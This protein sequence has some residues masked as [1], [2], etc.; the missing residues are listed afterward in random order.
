MRKSKTKFL[1]SSLII[2]FLILCAAVAIIV[3]GKNM[4]DDYK[5]QID[6]MQYEMD[7][8]KQTVYVASDEIKAGMTLEEGVNIYKQQIYTGLE[9]ESYISEEDIG[10]VAI[11]D[12]PAGEPIM[13]STVTP[14]YISPDTREY[15]IA[16]AALM[17]DQTEYE[18][19]DVRIMF[20]TGEDY[21]VLSKK[22]VLN[23]KLESSVFYSYLNEDEIMRMASAVIDAY[24]V[25]GT[26]IYTTRYVE[27]NLQDEA[28][29]NYLVKAETIDLI[30]RDP[31]ITRIAEDTLNLQAR[32]DL[33]NRLK[34]LTEDQLK[35]VASGH[36][37]E[38]TAKNAVLLDNTYSLSDSGLD[39]D[40]E[41]EDE[42]SDLE[43][44]EDATRTPSP[45]ASPTPSP[46]SDV[47]E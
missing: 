10:S 1:I 28:T 18:Y 26:R 35:A 45:S 8:N 32:M 42:M 44:E 20:P 6:D 43:E 2:T 23:L 39:S 34:G 9:S 29:P 27:Q 30:N 19:V 31:N 41:T 3:I 12:I 7:A 17:T 15:E 37:L 11:I 25:S 4:I 40:E 38:D 22:P 46:T 21:I 5:M 16:V 36:E 13:T 47:I 14:L 24:T 33:E